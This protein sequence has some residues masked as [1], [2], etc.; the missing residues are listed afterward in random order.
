MWG[1]AGIKV[2][3]SQIE[4][5]T[6]IDNLVTGQVPG[7][8][9]RDVRRPDPDLNY[10]WLSP[11]TASRPIA[12][13]FARNKDA[14]LEA[15]LQKGRTTSDQAARDP[16]PTRR[17]TSASRPTSPISGSRGRRGR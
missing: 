14:A 2:T 7:L 15:A 5:V 13:N 3:V 10:V 17:W 1:Q 11:T 6:Y 4:Q 8:R 9:R 16:R 12:L